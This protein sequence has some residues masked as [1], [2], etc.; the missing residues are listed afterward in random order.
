MT[1]LRKSFIFIPGIGYRTERELWKNDIITWDDFL[2]RDRAPMISKDK[3][4]RCD[5]ILTEASNR[6]G[7]GD[8]GYFSRLFKQGESW[9]LFSTFG[10]RARYLDIETT[11]TRR[12]SPITVVGVWD[13][14]RYDAAVRGFNLSTEKIRDM[15]QGANLIVT[16][17]GSTFDLPLLRH[18]FPGSVPEI[19]HM[20]L[21]FVALKSGFRGGLKDLE[22]NFGIRRPREVQGMSGEDAVRLWNIYEKDHN[23]QALKLI[24]KYNREDI[25]NLK[26]ISHEIVETLTNRVMHRGVSQ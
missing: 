9:R 20:D 14:V 23:H 26:T 17:N 13:G 21:R 12:D 25:V 11:G 18:Q 10:S 6:L 4:C 24:L 16:F 5:S 15:L 1:M 3:K 7:S 8:L 22:L 2:K 19:P